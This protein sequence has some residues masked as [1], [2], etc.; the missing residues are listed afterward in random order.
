MSDLIGNT[1]ANIFPK[2]LPDSM[3][4]RLLLAF[5]ATAGLFYVNIMPALVDGLV[6]GLGF[7]NKE[8]G[9]VG[10]SNVYGAAVGALLIVFLIS[11]INW[12]TAAWVF[13]SGL[14]IIDA[15][16][17]FIDDAQ[18]LT[19]LRFFHGLIGGMLVGTGF[20]VI[21]RTHKPDR[22]FGMLLGVQY[23]LGGLGIMVIPPLVPDFGTPILFLTLIGFSLITALMLPFI[24]DYPIDI[25]S[26]DRPEHQAPATKL[27]PLSLTLLALFLFQAANM[28]VF[29]YIIIL[30]KSFGLDPAF[31][32]PV[33]GAASWVGVL[34]AL[35]VVVF[36][37]RFGRFFPVLIGMA[38]TLVATWL[39]HYS[40]S[41]LAFIIAN[42]AVGI[43]WAFIIA[44]LLGMSA[45]F[46][47]AGR[48]AA[49]GGFASKMGLASG[50]FVAALIVGDNNYALLIN[51]A[52]VFM[53]IS[54]I[55]AI[56][57]ARFLDREAN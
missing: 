38:V 50:P 48:M 7:T 20:A 34:G 46:D 17:I 6:E 39:L 49:L 43:T 18:L 21:A 16:S 24:P 2:P 25:K 57:P 28:A 53:A 51:V 9:L 35:L 33:L 12:R 10:S 36:S 14:I 5:L 37:T 27:R 54:M 4:A 15:A 45:E 11:R 13:L 30:G 19:S 8:A 29:A 23:G 32:M 1:N 40:G 44:Y 26:A 42:C 31:I 56:I 41:P 22:T 47:K 52:L 55:A 3:L